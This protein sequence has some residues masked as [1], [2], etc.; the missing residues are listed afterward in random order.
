MRI[1]KFRARSIQEGKEKVFSELGEDAIILSSRVIPP[2]PPDMEEMIELVAAIDNN[3]LSENKLQSKEE[4]KSNETISKTDL[5]NITSEIYKEISSLKSLLWNLSD[6]ITYSFISKYEP[7]LQKL[8][9]LMSK[10]GFST[11]FI[12]DTLNKFNTNNYVNF[13]ELR[14]F[15]LRELTK[16]INYSRGFEKSDKSQKIIFIGP[17]GSGK[18]L[19]LVKIAVL[20]KLLLNA[21][22]AVISADNQKVGGS[23][24]LQILCAITNLPYN[25][26]QNKEELI[27]AFDDYKRYDFVMIDTNGGSPKDEAFI[28]ELNDFAS[29]SEINEVVL[30]LPVTVSSISCKDAFM[31]FKKFNPT[32]T[33]LTKF[34]EVSTI[35][36]IYE[37]LANELQNIPLIYCTNGVSIP[38]SIE[39][40]EP[41]F[42]S[43]YLLNY[44]D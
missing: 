4:V 28:E 18:T 21:K 10:N 44:F 1:K 17:S 37:I 30:V 25:F 27:S 42:I 23:E 26:V 13:E 35:G 12:L 5:I 41:E 9:K 29:L 14:R 6:K 20:L 36:H 24:Q 38:N 11:D 16:K 43:K 33:V 2:S 3:S 15:V 7:D 34:D 31:V 8:G 39:P 32:K 22:V 19:T 40:A